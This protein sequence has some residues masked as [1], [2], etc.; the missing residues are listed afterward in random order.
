MDSRRTILI[1][2]AVSCVITTVGVI[3]CHVNDAYPTAMSTYRLAYSIIFPICKSTSLKNSNRSSTSSFFLFLVLTMTS[4]LLIEQMMI[5]DGTVAP[6]N[7]LRIL[8]DIAAAIV[9]LV[10]GISATI[11]ATRRYASV[12]N[13]ID[14]HGTIMMIDFSCD[15]M[16]KH[17]FIITFFSSV[18]DG[19]IAAVIAF[20]GMM[21]YL[22]EGFIRY[23]K[24][25]PI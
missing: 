4:F 25:R 15:S 1:L 20:L 12:A 6:L 8:F 7:R 2:M 19:V 21:V 24:N 16:N 23:R 22:I 5:T 17:R 14:Y 13:V 18:L 11:V 10:F 9:L 3:H